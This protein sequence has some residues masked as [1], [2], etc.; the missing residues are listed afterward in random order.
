MD[1]F[2]ARLGLI[3]LS[4]TFNDLGFQLQFY[5]IYNFKF[6]SILIYLLARFLSVGDTK[7]RDIK[8]Y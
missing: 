7:E 6:E 1:P 4:L 8:Y 5:K 3:M 2:N